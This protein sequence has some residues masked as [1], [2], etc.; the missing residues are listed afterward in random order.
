MAIYAIEFLNP[1]YLGQTG[2]QEVSDETHEVVAVRFDNGDEVPA[3]PAYAY[4]LV[5]A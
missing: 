4:K 1:E 3:D 5:D 2:T